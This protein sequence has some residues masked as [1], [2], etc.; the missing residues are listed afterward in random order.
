LITAIINYCSI[1]NEKTTTKVIL[2]N[3]SDWHDWYESIKTKAETLQ[4]WTY[5]DPRGTVE[6]PC[7]TLLSEE[8]TSRDLERY[9]INNS[10]FKYVD[11]QLTTIR[12]HLEE[13]VANVHRI[14]YVGKPG[15]R[16][17]LQALAAQLKPTEEDLREKLRGEYEALCKVKMIT[18]T[19]DW[20]SQWVALE[21]RLTATMVTNLT[22]EE[23]RKGFVQATKDSNPAFYQYITAREQDERLEPQENPLLPILQA[24][25]QLMK[26]LST[27]AATT[28]GSSATDLGPESQSTTGTLN[29][30]LRGL[31]K[32]LQDQIENLKVP[33]K[34][35]HTMT[36]Y[37][38]IYRRL[39]Y[40]N[41]G[42][43]QRAAYGA[44]GATLNGEL[45][46][47]GTQT[48]KKSLDE[49][50]PKRKDT[51]KPCI[52]GYHHDYKDCWVLNPTAAKDGWTPK[53]STKAKVIKAFFGNDRLADTIR[54]VFNRHSLM[55]ADYLATKDDSS[56]KRVAVT[57]K[58]QNAKPNSKPAAAYA[59]RSTRI[60]AA[61]FS[62]TSSI[63]SDHLRST[64][65][66][67][68]SCANTHICNDLER[69]ETFSPYVRTQL[70][71]GSTTE[72]VE[73]TG[74]V[75]ITVQGPE[76]PETI[77]LH[78]VL[79][80]PGYAFNL[81]SY[82]RL[83]QAGATW[84]DTT[85]WIEVKNR[86]AYKIWDHEGWPIIEKDVIA[87]H[88]MAV[89][90][91]PVSIATLETWHQ[92]MGHA[93]WEAIGHLPFATGGVK[94]ATAK[95]DMSS[96]HCKECV[97]GQMTAKP[98]K[99]PPFKGTYSFEKVHFDIIP[100]EKAWNADRHLLHLYCAYSGFRM[101]YTLKDKQAE[102]IIEALDDFLTLT[103]T[104][105]Y[106][107]RYFQTDSDPTFVG[108]V[109]NFIR[110]RGITFN[111]SP[112]DTQDQNGF[113]ERSG[114]TIVE[115]A[116][117]I[118]TATGLP[119]T[120]WPYFVRHATMVLNRIPRRKSTSEL[121]WITPFEAV[122]GRKPDVSGYRIL[123]SKAYLLIKTDDKRS[124]IYRQNLERMRPK[125]VE[126]WLVGMAPSTGSNIYQVWFPKIG[127]RVLNARDVRID[128]KIRYK[129]EQ[130]DQP[131][132]LD[133]QLAL[134]E[135]DIDDEELS[136]E[137]TR[138]I[139]QLSVQTTASKPRDSGRAYPSP[140]T[141]PQ[142]VPQALSHPQGVTI[143]GAASIS[144]SV[145]PASSTFSHI[146]VVSGES[147][148]AQHPSIGLNGAQ[149][150]IDGG[151]FI[152]E[153]TESP[154]GS[155]L[156]SPGPQSG[157]EFREQTMTGI[158]LPY[159][160]TIPAQSLSQPSSLTQND[161]RRSIGSGS[162]C[163][164]VSDLAPD[165]E[166]SGVAPKGVIETP[167]LGGSLHTPFCQDSINPHASTLVSTDGQIGQHLEA[168]QAL[169][170]P[171]PKKRRVNPE[172]TAVT[173]L[174]TSSGRAVKPSA[175]AKAMAVKVSARADTTADM[176]TT[177]SYDPGQPPGVRRA[178]AMAAAAH[179]RIGELPPPPDNWKAMLR[180]P[181]SEGFKR[182]AQAE[183]NQLKSNGTWEE[184][185][186]PYGK[187]VIP[188]RWVFTYKS[189]ETG[190]L[191]R[192]KARICV[193]GDL[194]YQT[195]NDFYAATGA[196]RSFR[197]LMALV[198]AFGLICQQVDVKNAFT[199][200][201]MDEEVYCYAPQGFEIPGMVIRLLKALYG[202]RRS[203]KLWYD[204]L[205]AYLATLDFIPCP[206]DPCILTRKADSLI[207]FIFVDDML[208]IGR[209]AQ[210]DTIKQ[211]KSQLD[212][213]YGIA[214]LGDAT[215]FLNIRITRDL[216]NRKLWLTQDAYIDKLIARFHL[217]GSRKVSTPLPPGYDPSLNEG[218]ATEGQIKEYQQKI[219]S[220]IY[221][222]VV[223]RPD[224]AFAASNL[225][226][227]LVNPS[228]DHIQTANRLISYLAE[229]KNLSIEYSGDAAT[230]LV[231]ASDAS[232]ADD[233]TTRRSTQGYLISLYHGPIDWASQRQK[234]V[235]TSTTEAE[236]LA[237]SMIG[238]QTMALWRLFK[239]IE[240]DPAQ[241][242]EIF[243]DNKQTVGLI[244][245]ASPQFTSRL[246]HVDIHSHWLRQ[247][248]RD[249]KFL[250]SWIP[251]AEMPADGFTKALS[252]DKHAD[253]VKQLGMRDL[254]NHLLCFQSMS[255]GASTE[256]VC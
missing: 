6:P 220:V 91:A 48:N 197:L 211:L 81:V 113:A 134:A 176:E 125:A 253:F 62:V 70:T 16:E 164:V 30:P 56:S 230:P 245:K 23:A 43:R 18:K 156:V 33:Q 167:V 124:P 49:P 99:I 52:C 104:W 135:I 177:A 50:D 185:A 79:Y 38:G 120:L 188:L 59:L 60:E 66:K 106:T 69:F 153:S 169:S 234:T 15:I 255:D 217:E 31:F 68:D 136:A 166:R 246:K 212:Q 223:A 35:T 21:A 227:F 128:E 10:N 144:R 216:G 193:R 184:V 201:H 161:N 61:A 37:V 138:V 225:S 63:V 187:Q 181:E 9:K 163:T 221:P 254:T 203:P 250:I 213:K 131:A 84:N 123:G 92:R 162:P 44:E 82:Q 240:F 13:T 40:Q 77:H 219:G 32:D 67:L 228:A 129:P 41:S 247:E 36:E 241:L 58:P 64:L 173:Q 207:I 110:D 122:F 140:P 27:D 236:L 71:S 244:Q 89:K 112:A 103:K 202:L 65:F 149:N 191:Q 26:A 194:Q 118:G 109:E 232:F 152:I 189:D 54:R 172:A 97:L 51:K 248:Y 222:S 108:R 74:M 87:Y 12:N 159:P 192:H 72:I 251:T 256:G 119:V 215:S 165:T 174:R 154:P 199:N 53:D 29:E 252:R 127:H 19:E 186:K 158:Q 146:S 42:K 25:L 85:G 111:Q 155:P 46:P 249:N 218:Q 175:K 116:V 90:K 34:I 83:K 24:S 73:G 3:P 76:G 239:Q 114:R 210:T 96:D 168:S 151:G 200:A 143:G 231:V 178:F 179:K 93:G 22:P 206:E 137:F 45:Q 139:E 195:D 141:T 100:A 80:A 180:H 132:P 242:P 243:C 101:S 170:A 115:T 117:K 190:Y 198:C 147:P 7:F 20:L 88:A 182:A 183:I 107:V 209:P 28:P 204:E 233:K 214:D 86:K 142:G 5:C 126:G 226:R 8:A 17:R 39:A 98:S 102:S 205:T 105:G 238:R 145:S 14:H 224:I 1:M 237:L 160:A 235:T 57:D 75:P 94:L 196:Y 11:S 150:V 121:F 133:D 95:R 229:T 130:D 55:L 47:E 157:R 4:V 78:E 208:L 171:S 2:K 148:S